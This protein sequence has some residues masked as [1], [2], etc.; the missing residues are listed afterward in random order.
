MPV[1]WWGMVRFSRVVWRESRATFTWRLFLARN[2]RPDE[3]RIL[4]NH[5]ARASAVALSDLDAWTEIIHALLA[6]MDFR[7]LH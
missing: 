4:E 1:F 6:S 2:P 3:L 7:T 5:L